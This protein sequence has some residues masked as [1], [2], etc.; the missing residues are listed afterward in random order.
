MGLGITFLRDKNNKHHQQ[1]LAILKA[2]KAAN[3]KMPGEVEDYFHGAEEDHP[4]E[5]NTI[6]DVKTDADLCEEYIKLKVSD[7]PEGTDIIK[8]WCSY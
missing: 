5:I 3:I 2:C 7:I 4:L 1:M 8:I 6:T